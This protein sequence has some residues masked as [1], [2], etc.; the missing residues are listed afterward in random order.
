MENSVVR[1]LVAARAL[2]RVGGQ[3]QLEAVQ[4]QLRSTH[5]RGRE[6]YTRILLLITFVDTT[7]SATCRVPFLSND[8]VLRVRP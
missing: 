2:L 5:T 8:I 4:L 1:V 6:L 3:Q 7:E